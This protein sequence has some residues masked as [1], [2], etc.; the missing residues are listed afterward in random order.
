LRAGKGTVFEGGIRVPFVA[1]WTG[2]LPAGETFDLPVISLDVFPTA[3]AAAGV[4]PPAGLKLDGVNLLPSVTGEVCAPPHDILFWRT[5]G[6]QSLAV[7]KSCHKLVK[8]G[9]QPYSLFNL[10]DDPGETRDLAADKPG[11][12]A[13][14]SKRLETWN[15]ELVKPLFESPRP[16]PKRPAASA[17][18]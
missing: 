16:A 4:A 11:I 7:R 10:A 12:V 5:G 15:G 2:R 17:A 8:V 13:G 6:G 9:P 18:K 14:L 1:R 3:L